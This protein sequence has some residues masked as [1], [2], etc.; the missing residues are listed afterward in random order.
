MQLT[1]HF[2][3][4]ELC[5]SQYATRRGIDMTPPPQAKVALIAL[6]ENILE[7]LRVQAN[8]P[9]IVSSGYRSPEVNRAIGGSA[10]SQHCKGEAAD[11][12][13]PRVSAY[14]LAKMIQAM[15]LPFD[16]LILEFGRWVHV[17]HKAFGEQRG[18]V[19]TAVH[20]DGHAQYL[21][22]LIQ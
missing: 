10:T 2:S 3:L 8:R 4:D 18:Q 9:I 5:V 15:G 20:K 6:A 17:S 19:L 13:L 22:G 14:T 12:V 11:I 21:T 1:K 16:Q 7:P